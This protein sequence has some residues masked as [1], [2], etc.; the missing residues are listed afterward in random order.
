MRSGDGGV[1]RRIQQ[2]PAHKRD[3]QNLPRACIIRQRLCAGA[4]DQGVQPH[5]MAKRA[6]RQRAGEPT[7]AGGEAGKLGYYKSGDPRVGPHPGFNRAQQREILSAQAQKCF[8]NVFHEQYYGTTSA[9]AL[10]LQKPDISASDSV[11]LDLE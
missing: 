9:K 3:A 4:V 6:P 11:D 2:Q 7:V 10:P 1:R 8:C 5:Q